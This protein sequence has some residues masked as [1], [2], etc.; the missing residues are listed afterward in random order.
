MKKRGFSGPWSVL[1]LTM[2]PAFKESG[3]QKVQGIDVGI[4]ETNGLGQDGL[5][6]EQRCG[7]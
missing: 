4:A 7:T 2:A 6:G 1:A 5:A 3:L